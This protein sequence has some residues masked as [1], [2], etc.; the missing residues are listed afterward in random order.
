M[1]R[2]IV[3]RYI[4]YKD[5]KISHASLLSLRHHLSQPP[6]LLP[7]SQP[8][9]QHLPYYP[10]H[11]PTTYPCPP[12]SPTTHLTALPPVPALLPTL[13]YD[14]YLPYPT[15]PYDT[16]HC[17]TTSTCPTPPYSTTCTCPTPP[18]PTTDLTASP[19]THDLLLYSAIYPRSAYP[20]Y[21]HTTAY[22]LLR[23]HLL[24]ILSRTPH[25]YA[26]LHTAHLPHRCTM[27][28]P[29]LIGSTTQPYLGHLYPPFSS[30]TFI[31]LIRPIGL[32][33]P[34]PT[35]ARTGQVVGVIGLIGAIGLIPP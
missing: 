21:V 26:T 15:Q 9:D 14:L 33:G 2:F 5:S 3:Y 25:T 4:S 6:A 24:H 10:P 12:P 16:P 22:P 29:Y 23:S 11:C 27:P 28:P 19:P 35:R 1:L 20:T 7:T 34:T 13:L 17:P 30:A 18:S 31:G 32:I 8:Y